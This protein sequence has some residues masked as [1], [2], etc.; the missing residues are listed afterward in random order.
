M[1]LKPIDCH[2]VYSNPNMYDAESNFTYD[3]PFYLGLA[4][5]FGG[6]VLE[7]ACGTGRV[8]IPLAA[9]G[10]SVTGLD[11]S[12]PF[13]GRAKEKAREADVTA[14]FVEADCR[15]FDLGEK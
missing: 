6:P 2:D 14:K 13:I 9:E 1:S 3:I 11:M 7:L 10:F 12:S 4:K 15:E 5:E 8:S